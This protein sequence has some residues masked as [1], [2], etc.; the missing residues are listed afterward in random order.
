MGL[1]SFIS[2]Q[3]I[4]VIQWTDMQPG[5]LAYRYPMQDMEIQN[6]AQLVVRESQIATFY[7]EGKFADKF[8]PGTYTLNTKTLP[9]LT[10]LKNWDKLFESPFKS[11]VY[12]FNALDQVDRKWGTTQPVTVR[13]TDFGAIRIRAFGSY[14]YTIDNVESFWMKLCGAAATYTTEAIEGQLRMAILTTIST[15]LGKNNGSFIDLAANQQ[16]L[17]LQLQ[18][19]I[20]PLFSSYGLRLT[21]FFVTNI[22]LPEELQQHFDRVSSMN[23][24][25][26]IDKY[27]QLQ[28]SDAILDLANN[29]SGS[30]ATGALG[31]GAGF[32][33]NQMMMDKVMQPNNSKATEDYVQTLEN[34]NNLYKKG[35]L[36]QQEF[37]AKKAE[38]L[39]KIK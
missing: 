16:Q 28:A 6:G 3:F 10:Y 30:A 23:M 14:S 38:I 32:A 26:D 9:V 17:S 22:S 2:K 11:D 19:E 27:S 1:R 35:I 13:D 25:K 5:I 39:S 7:N 34:L 8:G 29:Q 18:D 21:S 33:F 37:E 24:I 12:F 36:T 15:A 4:D 20:A 31:L